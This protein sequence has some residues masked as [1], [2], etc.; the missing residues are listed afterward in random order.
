MLDLSCCGHKRK[1]KTF[2]LAAKKGFQSA[3]LKCGYCPV[4]GKFSV[5]ICSISDDNKIKITRKENDDAFI[6]FENQKP[7]IIY[8]IKNIKNYGFGW[9]L[10]YSEYGKIKKCYSN[11][12]TLKL[13][14][15]KENFEYA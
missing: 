12:R 1:G 2:A 3:F 14:K 4:C 13:G 8:E 10:C 15:M 9:Y 11:L 6:L 5:I 7:N